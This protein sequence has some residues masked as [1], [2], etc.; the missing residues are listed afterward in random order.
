M[1]LIK[2]SKIPN[3][4][5][6]WLPFFPEALLLIW[7]FGNVIGISVIRNYFGDMTVVCCLLMS[8]IYQSCIYCGLIETNTRYTE[9]FQAAGGISAEITDD[10]WKVLDQYKELEELQVELTER[11]RL[12]QIAYEK[13]AKK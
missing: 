12:L 2:K 3:K 13:K 4:R 10:R 9:L 1:I 8:A 7:S 11:N 5:R 6:T